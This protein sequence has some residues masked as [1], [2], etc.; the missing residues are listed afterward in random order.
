LF[1]TLGTPPYMAPEIVILRNE[2]E[3]HPGYGRP[4][5]VW[6]LGI[7]LYIL[8]SGIHPYQIED[9]DKM[10]DNIEAGLWPGWKGNNWNLISQD[11]KDL[12]VGMM[13]PNPKKRFS[14]Q[15]CLE[16]PWIVKLT[17]ASEAEGVA[18]GGV[19]DS[20]KTYQAKKKFK[21]A[22]MGIMATNKLQLLINNAAAAKKPANAAGSDPPKKVLKELDWKTL[23]IQVHAGKALAPK[24]PNGKSD[25]YVTLWCGSSKPFKTKIKYKTLNPEWNEEIFEL[26]AN[27]CDGKTLEFEVWDHDLIPPDEFMGRVCVPVDSIQKGNVYKDWYTLEKS[28][29]KSKKK[30]PSKVKFC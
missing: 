30:E 6:A 12:I 14:I 20:I 18:L 8:L 3:D 25:P 7:C 24:D 27:V 23:K 19:Q 22:V 17:G 10:L 2:D 28:G 26:P 13:N 4:V 15:Q 16:C 21:G 29:D 9:E 11:A 5:D 1:E